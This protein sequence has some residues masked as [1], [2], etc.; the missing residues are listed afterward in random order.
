MAAFFVQKNMR[1]RITPDT[2]RASG[3]E[4][5]SLTDN[6]LTASI[7]TTASYGACNS[8]LLFLSFAHV[9]FM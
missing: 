4:S 5:T 8:L 2:Q 1:P 9:V 7:R 3:T 6:M